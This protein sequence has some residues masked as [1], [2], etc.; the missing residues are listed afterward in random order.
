MYCSDMVSNC[1]AGTDDDVIHV[2]TD[3]HSAQC[4]T[5]N[6]GVE[7]VVHHCLERSR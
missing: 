4:V 7:N 5:V 2:N 3:G 6:K 1:G